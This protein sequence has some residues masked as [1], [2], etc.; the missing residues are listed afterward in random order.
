MNR[1][2]AEA[3]GGLGGIEGRQ[4]VDHYD[5]DE[6]T[7]AALEWELVVLW[8]EVLQRLLDHPDPRLKL[9]G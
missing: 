5:P 3:K 9:T 6:G 2:K 4:Q 8:A 7:V 1:R